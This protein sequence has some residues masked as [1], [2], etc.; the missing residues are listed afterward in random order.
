MSIAMKRAY[1]GRGVNTNN[2]SVMY[3]VNIM[4]KTYEVRVGNSLG[5]FRD[6]AY[7]SAPLIRHLWDWGYSL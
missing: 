1:P 2:N 3:P 4:K 7:S 6:P 5:N